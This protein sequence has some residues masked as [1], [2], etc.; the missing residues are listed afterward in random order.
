MGSRPNGKVSIFFQILN[1]AREKLG[2]LENL[3]FK[4]DIV[5]LDEHLLNVDNSPML[6]VLRDYLF[7]WDQLKLLLAYYCWDFWIKKE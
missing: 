7:L 4:Y 2:T 5:C 1:D 3:L 6:E